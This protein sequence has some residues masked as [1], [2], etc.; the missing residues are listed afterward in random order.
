MR[1]LWPLGFQ[2]RF[3]KH[4]D[5]QNLPRLMTLV[6]GC[7]IAT[8]RMG[9]FGRLVAGAQLAARERAFTASGCRLLASYNCGAV[10]PMHVGS[11]IGAD[12][13]E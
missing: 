10:L 12:L 1:L 5:D 11:C 13:A 8:G 6:K 3:H 4:H 7:W 9:W 2:E